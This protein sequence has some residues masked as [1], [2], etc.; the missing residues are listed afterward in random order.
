MTRG[1]C[2]VGIE[3]PKR[4]VNQGT[5]WRSAV[6]LGASMTFT[7]GRRYHPQ[8]S[9][10]GKSWRS[11]PYIPYENL[12]AFEK[13]RPFD[14]PVIGVE[15]TADSTPLETFVHPERCLYLLGP[16]DGSLS[17]AALALC[18]DVVSF[19]SA[20]CLNVAMAGT[21]VMYDRHVKA[22]ARRP[23]ERIA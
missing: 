18:S 19:S 2:G 22:M 1:W 20:Y 15:I 3:R 6:C 16:E 11:V 7:I 21:V 13:A 14:V 12:T 8:P 4:E 10:T 23:L 9:D 5:L 17:N